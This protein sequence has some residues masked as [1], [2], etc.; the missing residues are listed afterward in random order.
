MKRCLKGHPISSADFK[1]KVVII[2]FW[3][4][5]CG[6][7]QAEMPGNQKLFNRYGSQGIVV[8]DGYRT[9]YSPQDRFFSIFTYCS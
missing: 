1:G 8:P 4:T 2:D 5:W 7:V 9:S 6:T 3:A